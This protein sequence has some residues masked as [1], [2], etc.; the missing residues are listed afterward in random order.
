VQRD[1]LRRKRDEAE[2]EQREV[3]DDRHGQMVRAPFGASAA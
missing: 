1:Q 3:P 2:R